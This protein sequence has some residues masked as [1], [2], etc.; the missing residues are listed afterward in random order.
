MHYK[1]EALKRDLAPVEKFLKEIGVEG[2][3]PLPKL[4]LNKTSMPTTTQVIL[5]TY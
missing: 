1:T 3:E 5:L 2:V 4:S